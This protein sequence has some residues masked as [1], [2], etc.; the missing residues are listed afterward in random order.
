MATYPNAEWRPLAAGSPGATMDAHDIVCV[1][2]MV[3]TLGGTESMFR[4]NG[5]TGTESHF[6]VGGPADGAL[7]GT[8][9]QWV[10][11]DDQADANLQGNHRLISIETSD[12]GDETNPWSDAQLDAIT[13]II[14]WACQTYAIPAALVAD[15]TPGQ[16]GIG[17]HRQGIDPWRV[18]GGERWSS[19]NGKVCPG[20]VRI[21]QLVDVV[22][23][24]VQA[25]VGG[26]G[27]VSSALT[28]DAVSPD[29]GSAG[30]Q[31]V[32]TGSGFATADGVSFA[33]GWVET[34]S[35][36]SD[37]QITATVPEQL[38]SGS[39]A[40]A[41][42]T[43][44]ST[45]DAVWFTYAEASGPSLTLSGVSPDTGVAGSQVVLD[46]AGFLAAN[47]VSF[48]DVWVDTWTIDSDTQITA[49]V[50]EPVTSGS[51]WVSVS[52]PDAT[53]ESVAFAY[54]E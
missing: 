31:V 16:R 43:P 8:V 39:V 36:D 11:T 9:Y 52:A 10:D 21:G 42:S 28:L 2:T 27:P 5:W 20:D 24:R 23:P 41:V 15:S 49:S 33:G 40:V 37:T 44:G 47:G 45:S 30:D 13:G 29:T 34:W 12:G 3:G 6:G 46:G 22:I 35:I 54:E 17:Y 14:V 7:D 51:V 50:P 53:S 4:Q 19:S 25:Q 32:L 18:A 38:A 48:G 26:S 1:H